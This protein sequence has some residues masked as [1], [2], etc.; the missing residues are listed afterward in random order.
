MAVVALALLAWYLLRCQRQL[1][2]QIEQID[3]EMGAAQ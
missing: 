3:A 2:R 1:N